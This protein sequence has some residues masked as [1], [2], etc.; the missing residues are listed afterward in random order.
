MMK[1]VM[2]NLKK[3]PLSTNGRDNKKKGCH[4]FFLV[5]LHH[6]S[7]C[8]NTKFRRDKG[9]IGDLLTKT[10][11]L[12]RINLYNVKASFDKSSFHTTSR[13][14]TPTSFHEW[15]QLKKTY[16]A[17]QQPCAKLQ[18]SVNF[19]KSLLITFNIVN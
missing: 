18:S 2:T 3:C 11:L 15:M 9:S 19:L 8:L 13:I 10:H 16:H 1:K 14:F 12:S 17:L 5:E 4:M 7:T 6:L